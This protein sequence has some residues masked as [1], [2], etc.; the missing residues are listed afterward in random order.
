MWAGGESLQDCLLTGDGLQLWGQT[1]QMEMFH[2][3]LSLPNCWSWVFLETLNLW[4]PPTNF[5]PSHSLWRTAVKNKKQPLKICI[6]FS[7]RQSYMFCHVGACCFPHTAILVM[8]TFTCPWCA[9]SA[10]CILP[11]PSSHNIYCC[12]QFVR[13]HNM[14]CCGWLREVTHHAEKGKTLTHGCCFWL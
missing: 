1:S 8:C 4:I 10:P 6:I 12:W 14:V 13:N 2:A 7:S 3:S 9:F 11:P 5:P